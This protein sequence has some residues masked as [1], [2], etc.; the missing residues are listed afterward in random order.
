MF[1]EILAKL[2]R[3]EPKIYDLAVTAAIR[4]DGSYQIMKDVAEE[5]ELA[6]ERRASE[7]KPALNLNVWEV[8]A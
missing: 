2:Q 8:A 1:M 6:E 7:N 4:G 3:A 5:I